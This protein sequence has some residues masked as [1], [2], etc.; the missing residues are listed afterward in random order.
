MIINENYCCRERHF[1]REGE[2][3][4]E[5]WTERGSL[6]HNDCGEEDRDGCGGRRDEKRLM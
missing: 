5:N 4:R 2:R 3:E 6:R 1:G